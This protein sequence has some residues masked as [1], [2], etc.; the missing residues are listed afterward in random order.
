MRRWAD[1]EPADP[2]LLFEV[3]GPRRSHK[4]ARPLDGFM[5][6][7]NALERN[8]LTNPKEELPRS[9][10]IPVC[11]AGCLVLIPSLD[12]PCKPNKLGFFFSLKCRWISEIITLQ[13]LPFLCNVYFN[14]L[15]FSGVINFIE[16]NAASIPKFVCF[17]AFLTWRNSLHG[18]NTPKLCEP[19]YRRGRE[20]G[21]KTSKVVNLK[22]TLMKS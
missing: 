11:L 4:P 2:D 17:L 9:A 14:I 5:L 15:L 20:E 16:K 6:L 19:C 22:I 1:T 13:C 12:P 3:G 18:E 8:A 7:H 21:K 10:W